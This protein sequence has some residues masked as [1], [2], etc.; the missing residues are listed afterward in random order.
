MKVLITGGFG[1]VGGRLGEYLASFNHQIYLGSRSKRS[2]PSWLAKGSVVEMDWTDDQSLIAACKSM[3]VVIHAAGMNALECFNNPLMALEVNGV[4]TDRLVQVAQKSTVSKF[5]YIS[6]AHVY[7]D[8]LIGVITEEHSVT[9]LHPYAT[10]HFA[11]EQAVGNGHSQ[12]TM[13]SI[14]VRL[15]NSFGRP[16]FTDAKCWMLVV[17]NLCK[18][19]AIDRRLVLRDPPTTI[20]NFITM[21][22]VCAGIQF[23]IGHCESMAAS[24]ICNLGDK[25]QTIF[26]IATAIKTIYS[27]EKGIELEIFSLSNDPMETQHLD[28]QSLVLRRMGYLPSSNFKQELTK[29]IEFCEFQ[30]REKNE[31]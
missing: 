3:D 4:D 21:T 10:S 17:N 18:Q 29:L 28:F 11:G 8:N 30:F 27:D 14:V 12:S 26:D 6:S 25:T 2:R 15:A 22:D 31:S 16:S 9:N 1:F 19:A 20:R 7:S 23:I 24:K 5:V 13:Q